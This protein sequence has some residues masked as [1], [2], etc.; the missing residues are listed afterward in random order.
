ME[1]LGTG[2]GLA[3]LG[4]WTFV[5]TA[6]VAGVWD[7]IRKRDAQHETLRRMIESG[8]PIDH[9]LA[10]KLLSLSAADDDLPEQLRVAAYIMWA[11]SPGL[12]I[13]GAVLSLLAT[14]IFTILLGVAALVAT[15]GGGFFVASRSIEKYQNNRRSKQ[16]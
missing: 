15:L 13:L 6:V 9:E 12:I 16:L 1:G 5:G 11:I 10:N 8:Q 3:A 4:F 14:E 7:S 2:A